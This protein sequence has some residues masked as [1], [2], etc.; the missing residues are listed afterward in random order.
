MAPAGAAPA[1]GAPS[2]APAEEPPPAPRWIWLAGGEAR[3]EHAILRRP[4]ALAG[5]PRAATLRVVAD[6]AEVD[7]HL[8]GAHGG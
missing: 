6:F 3:A 4:F 2:E 7:V 8:N 5:E 1:A